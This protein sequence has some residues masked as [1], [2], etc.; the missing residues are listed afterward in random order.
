MA[1]SSLRLTNYGTAGNVLG[2]IKWN[3]S[4]PSFNPYDFG[5][6]GATG[7]STLPSTY[8]SVTDNSPDFAGLSSLFYDSDKILEA[9]TV[10]TAGDLIAT[11]KQLEKMEDAL[12]GGGGG[13]ESDSNAMLQGGLSTLGAVAGSFLPFPGGS[14]VG[15]FAGKA[16]GSLFT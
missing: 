7:L 16:L 12:G 10:D 1:R 4:D 3:P 13:G 5:A 6:A 8:K 2:G 15:A 11:R 14:A 9:N